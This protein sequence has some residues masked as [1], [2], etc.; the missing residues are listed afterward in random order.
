MKKKMNAGKMLLGAILSAA[1]VSTTNVVSLAAG[2]AP[3]NENVTSSLVKIDARPDFTFRVDLSNSGAGES[4]PIYEPYYLSAYKVTNAQY[5]EFISETSRKAPSYWSGGVYPEGK[6]NHPVLN[7][8]YSDAAAYCEWLS[9]KHSGWN[10]RLPTEAEWENAAMGDYYGDNSIKYP[11]G[12][13]APSYDAETGELKTTFNFNGVIA[14]KLFEEYGS[15]YIVTYVKGD[16]EGESEE[17]GEC[18]SI[19][20]NGGVINWANHGGDAEKGYFL[21]TDLYKSISS[22]GGYTTPVGTYPAN[23]LGLYDMAGN[24]WDLTSSLII[25]ENGAEKGEQCYA[26]R[27]GSWYATARS[28]TFI[29]RG[30]GRRDHASATVGF[31]IAADYNGQITAESSDNTVTQSQV[32]A[33]DENYEWKMMNGVWRLVNSQG[34]MKNGWYFDHDY[35]GWFYL[36]P[37]YGMQVGWQLVGGKWYYLNPVSDGTLGLMY[38]NRRTPDGYYVDAS[39]AWDGMER[40]N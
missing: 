34:N 27:G 22:E 38:A 16:Y 31:R 37:N 40:V 10:F 15:D 17:L 1:I 7:V 3:T 24:S 13:K 18:I 35:N 33:G 21:Q 30:E 11:D 12:S 29:Y 14:S 23:T 6:E 20:A 25:A 2:A 39:G 28:C 4:S 26:V 32:A 5:Y 8:S 19:R 36:D 9:D